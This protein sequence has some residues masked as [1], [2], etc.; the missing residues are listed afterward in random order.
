MA[1]EIILPQ[2]TQN[3][4]TSFIEDHY[5]GRAT[6]MAVADAVDEEFAKL[7]VNPTLGAVPVGTPFETRRI[8]RFNI[9]V[10]DR[11]HIVEL[12]YKINRISSTITLVGFRW[13]PPQRL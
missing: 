3:E 1:F 11:S 4:I 7:Q 5:I 2:D 6:Q 10:G 8:H 12:A 13:V 9:T